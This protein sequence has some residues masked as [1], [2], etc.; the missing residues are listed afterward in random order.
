MP[1]TPFLL[2]ARNCLAVI[3]L[4]LLFTHPVKAQ[5]FEYIEMDIGR[6][7]HR[8]SDIGGMPEASEGMHWPAELAGSNSLRNEAFWVGVKNWTNSDGTPLEYAVSRIGPRSGSLDLEPVFPVSARLVSKWKRTEVAVNGIPNPD[9]GS[10]VGDYEINPSLPADHMIHHVFRTNLG[11]EVDRKVYAYVNQF[12]DDYHVIER[13]ITNTGNVDGDEE[14]ELPNQILNEL[15]V[16]NIWRWTG[17]EEAGYAASLAQRWGKFNMIDIVGDGREEYDVDFTAIYSW[18]GYDPALRFDWSP[19]GSPSLRVSIETF[20][21]TSGRLTGMSMQGLV[22]LHADTSPSDGSYDPSEQPRSLGWIDSDEPLTNEGQSAR[23]YYELGILTREN[24]DFLPGGSSRMYP[25]YADRIVP[26]GDFDSSVNDASLGKQG[27]HAP[28]LAYGPYQLGSG[29][30]VR[31]VEAL[32]SNGLSLEAAKEI[33]RMYKASGFDETSLIEYDANNDGMINSTPF[34]FRGYNSGSEAL[35]KNQWFLSSKDSL[36]MTMERATALWGASNDMNTYPIVEP[37]APPARF[38]VL[39]LP[40]R[41]ELSWE[42]QE[43]GV[44]PISWEIYRTDS[45]YT[46]N[47]YERI[48]VLDGGVRSYTD[49][50]AQP[51]YDYYY[52]IQAVGDEQSVDLMAITGTPRGVPVRSSR[53][54]TQ[55]K[56]PATL[57][58]PLA[59]PAFVEVL[60][61]EDEIFND[62]FG[63]QVSFSGNY[64]AISASEDDAFGL[65]NGTVYV[66]ERQPDGRW[67][68]DARINI[69]TPDVF[70]QPEQQRGF[71]DRIFL[72]NGQLFVRDRLDDEVVSNAGAI[73]VYRENETGEWVQTGKVLSDSEF[74]G[75]FLGND[76]AAEENVLL[77]S[78]TQTAGVNRRGAIYT[79]EQQNDTTWVQ[80]QELFPQP[81]RAGTFRYGHSIA[82]RL[83]F[84]FVS[85]ELI[86]AS[87]GEFVH[88][89]ERLED[90]R[91]EERQVLKSGKEPG[92]LFGVDMEVTGNQLLAGAPLAE[93]DPTDGDVLEGAVYV[94]EHQPADNIWV[95]QQVLRM[96]KEIGGKGNFA[97]AIAAEGDRA[98][99][100]G[101]EV[102]A[103]F[104]RDSEGLWSLS[105][106]LRNIGDYS[107][108]FRT[109]GA[110]LDISGDF[111]LVG[112]PSTAGFV[113][114]AGYVFD[115]TSI[116]YTSV[117][118]HHEERSEV[119]TAFILEQNYPNPFNPVTTI[120]YEVPEAM[121]IRIVV[122]NTLGKR[123]KTLVDSVHSPGRY[124]VV[125]DSAN[126]AS[127]AYFYQLE[128]PT[129]RLIRTMMLLK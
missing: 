30:Q 56:I 121:E 53:Y 9:T 109:F 72:E 67:Q 10:M 31:V 49:R 36:L 84:A 52:Y 6:L 124:E 98:V 29:E 70:G 50:T 69:P 48:A 54:L 81:E 4:L 73:Y 42:A 116:T 123:V 112:A 113:E 75:N 65:D 13:T 22:V 32:A 106:T 83:P 90:G 126:L 110:S 47:P 25:H 55:T 8:Y 11:V 37:P 51:F 74:I 94:Y 127:G 24:L 63:R 107:R 76:I 59:P 96:P 86:G 122:Y 19:L 82:L 125:F 45:A 92:E 28:I 104:E 68:E 101:G 100:L 23:D 79:F 38:T 78:S 27:G 34:D 46:K 17:R 91:W 88:V 108:E 43:G 60:A 26:D 111:A 18:A 14:I 115:M 119:P 103:L 7:H 1:L 41:I 93:V 2:Q 85:A 33:G 105:R 120:E 89:F 102:V 71:G 118:D 77:A 58:E 5:F 95:L 15:M 35:T 16:Y 64:A 80:R 62:N 40:D 12:H 57:H 117:E 39:P 114:G 128:T 61:T 99:I 21:D 44:E 87:V 66:Y 97:G 20:P 3:L 129:K